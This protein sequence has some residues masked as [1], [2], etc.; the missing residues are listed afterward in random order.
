MFE[1]EKAIGELDSQKEGETSQSLRITS[2]ITLFM[3]LLGG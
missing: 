3:C 2:V 1:P